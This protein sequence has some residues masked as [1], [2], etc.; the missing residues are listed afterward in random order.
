MP[1]SPPKVSVL[2][3]VYNT[4]K[5]LREALDSLV[6]QTIFA[7]LEIICINDGS[8]DGSLKILRSYVQKYPK[9][10]VL[11][12]KKNTGY[13]DS[14]NRG[15]KKATGK[16]IGILESDD[17]IDPCAFQV[18]FALAESFNA[19]ISRANYYQHKTISEK[20]DINH[21]AKSAESSRGA[22]KVSASHHRHEIASQKASTSHDDKNAQHESLNLDLKITIDMP[23]E[24]GSLVDPQKARF[25]L[26]QAPAIWSAIYRRDFLEENKIAFLP[27]PGASYQDTSFAFKVWATAHRFVSTEKAFLHYR[28]DNESSSSNSPEKAFCICDEFVEIERFLKSTD[29]FDELKGVFYTRK[30]GA[31]LWNLDRL[32]VTQKSVTQK[33]AP[34]KASSAAQKS[35][36]QKTAVQKSASEP[37]T[38]SPNLAEK[39]LRRF[40]AEF[41]SVASKGAN[42]KAPDLKRSDFSPKQWLHLQLILRLPE[43]V[44]LKLREWRG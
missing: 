25:A 11:I 34:Q 40:R 39:F 26:L 32:C 23:P 15:L 28:V 17:F 22:K 7:D 21:D 12:N 18:L 31:Y 4:E 14:M 41:K 27:T 8:T 20:V 29:R 5:Y 1:K 24:V 42:S 16:Y 13:G 3:P 36:T 19:D 9:N 6:A 30:F 33:T 44:Y 2:V 10:F 38:Q 43:K 37:P 35:T